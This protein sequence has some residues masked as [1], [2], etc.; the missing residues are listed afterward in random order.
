MKEFK[1]PEVQRTIWEKEEINPRL[2]LYVKF[3]RQTIVDLIDFTA[4]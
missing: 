4:L 1:G 3:T 2:N